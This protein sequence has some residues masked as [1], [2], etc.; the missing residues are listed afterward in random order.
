MVYLRHK[1]S[2][3]YS[4]FITVLELGGGG[5]GVQVSRIVSVTFHS[6]ESNVFVLTIFFNY[7]SFVVLDIIIGAR[8]P[9]G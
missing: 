8:G 6:L 2:T 9:G 1:Y 7:D 5:S 3:L 4:T